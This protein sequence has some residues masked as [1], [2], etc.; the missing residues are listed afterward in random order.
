MNTSCHPASARSSRLRLLPAFVLLASSIPAGA[1]LAQWETVL[2]DTLRIG[3]YCE[4]TT[5]NGDAWSGAGIFGFVYDVQLADDF[6]ST[7]P[8]YLAEVTAD[9]EAF[10][11]DAPRDGAYVALFADSGGRPAEVP[12]A[13]ALTTNILDDAHDFD[14]DYGLNWHRLTARFEFDGPVRLPLTPGPCWIVL[15]PVDLS[16]DGDWYYV[17]RS[18]LQQWHHGEVTCYRDGA[19]GEG[20]Y[21]VTT[22]TPFEGQYGMAPGDV[23]MRVVVA[24]EARWWKPESAETEYGGYVSGQARWLRKY[25]GRSWIQDSRV[26]EQGD[27]QISS[28]TVDTHVNERNWPAGGV[29]IRQTTTTSLTTFTISVLR[30]DGVWIRLADDFKP[31]YDEDLFRLDLPAPAGDFI[32]RSAAGR[33]RLRLTCRT[34]RAD[35]PFRHSVDS[36]QWNLARE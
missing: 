35:R 3:S 27:G 15:Q 2:Y 16:E 23:S 7:R 28:L 34:A 21:G 19:R 33:M 5:A 8:G 11:L 22:W 32:D 30:N 4:E 25:D 20:G 14:C 6:S 36:V 31:E 10:L 9:Y 18:E 26:S 24:S 29:A 17:L 1:A 12:F 13:E